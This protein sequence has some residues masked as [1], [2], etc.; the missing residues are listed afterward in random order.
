VLHCHCPQIF[1]NFILSIFFC[2]RFAREFFGG[3]SYVTQNSSFPLFL[4]L[5][6]SRG[7][8]GESPLDSHLGNSH[9]SAQNN[10]YN[11]IR[12]KTQGIQQNSMYTAE[13]GEKP[14]V[15][16]RIQCIQ[17]NSMYTAESRGRLKKTVTL[18]RGGAKNRNFDR[19]RRT[20]RESE[21]TNYTPSGYQLDQLWGLKGAF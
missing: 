11:R 14:K 3:R 17:Q 13:S 12:E 1:Q 5:T 21:S 16:S 19:G 20:T 18:T 7:E 8:L 2:G 6:Q 4:F 15:Y 9:S 10:L